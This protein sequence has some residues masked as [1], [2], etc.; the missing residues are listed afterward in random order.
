LAQKLAYQPWGLARA[1][2]VAVQAASQGP[3]VEEEKAVRRGS[4][5]KHSS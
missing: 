3:A 5:Q 2:G 1:S 4:S